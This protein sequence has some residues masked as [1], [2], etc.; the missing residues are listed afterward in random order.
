MG[1]SRADVSVR[2][3]G[4]QQGLGQLVLPKETAGGVFLLGTLMRHARSTLT[5]KQ[6][7]TIIKTA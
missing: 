4:P 5:N 7:K 2:W 6:T 3:K 1:C